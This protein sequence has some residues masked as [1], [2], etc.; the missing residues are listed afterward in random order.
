MLQGVR[1]TL[2][3]GDTAEAHPKAGGGTPL[4][5][6]GC[7]PAARPHLPREVAFTGGGGGLLMANP[8]RQVT[9]WAPLRA[10][11]ENVA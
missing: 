6:Q 1:V 11:A 3:M 2:A 8:C 7:I 10:A 4:E 5:A 9:P